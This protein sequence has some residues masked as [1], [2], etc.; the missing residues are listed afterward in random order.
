MPKAYA[1]VPYSTIQVHIMNVGMSLAIPELKG[2][3]SEMDLAEVG[4]NR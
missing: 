1:R 2:L 3:S 4:I